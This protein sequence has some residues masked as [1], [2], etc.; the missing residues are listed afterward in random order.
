MS[1]ARDGQKAAAKALIAKKIAAKKPN[2]NIEHVPGKVSDKQFN[3]VLD[4]M[5]DGVSRKR[6]MQAANVPKELFRNYVHASEE[7]KQLVEEAKL[8]GVDELLD[9]TIDISD[10][11]KDKESAAA[12]SVRIN[13]RQT[14][15][16]MINQRRYNVQ[17]HKIS[18]DSENP[19]TVGVVVV[20]AKQPAPETIKQNAK[21]ADVKPVA[22][23]GR[24]KVTSP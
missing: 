20:P 9:E 4:L 7:R 1:K 23:A 15:A 22:K 3:L 19:L 21:A 11:A 2:K 12:A 14:Y 18:G 10:T 6:A 13:A 24:F 16:K 5:R 8:E 17:Q